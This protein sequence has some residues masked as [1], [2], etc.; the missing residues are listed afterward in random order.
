VR[1]ATVLRVGIAYKPN[2]ADT[3]ASPALQLATALERDGARVVFHDPLV[4]SVGWPDGT[5]RVSVPL[6][7]D[8]LSSADCAVILTDHDGI[9]WE[10]LVQSSQLVVD[11]RNATRSVDVGRER[12][13]LL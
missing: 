7:H 9:D 10:Q 5:R 13:V 2:V 12:I 6:D 8:T 11:T 3:F 1:G 4:P